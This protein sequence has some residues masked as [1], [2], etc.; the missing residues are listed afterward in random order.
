MNIRYLSDFRRMLC[1]SIALSQIE[2]VKKALENAEMAEIRMENIKIATTDIE[3]I[4]GSH[5]NL[6]ATCRPSISVSD[7]QRF[8]FMKT[9]VKAGAKWVDVEIESADE[10]ITDIV[11]FA[12]LNHC[13]SIISYHNYDET[14]EKEYLLEMLAIANNYKPDLIKIACKVNVFF[15]NATLL[16]LYETNFPLLVIGMG[17]L[18]KI[19]RIAALK[20]GAPFTFVKANNEKATADGQL[21]EYEMKEMLNYL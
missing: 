21:S 18:G 12:K 6:L 5:S 9:A 3:Q 15:D 1:R 4:F 13:K 10:Q 14:P 17:E 19:T 11:N 2:N 8:Q 20:L 7:E 16:S